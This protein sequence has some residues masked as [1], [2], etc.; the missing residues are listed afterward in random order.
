MPNQSSAK[1]EK[2]TP[3]YKIAMVSSEAVPYAKT[4]GLGDV[5][6]S[7]PKALELLG[8]EV[9]VFIPKYS[10]IDDELHKL[11]HIWSIGEIIIRVADH[12]YTVHLHEATL[13]GT[14]V[15]VYF[16]DC[17]HFFDRRWIYTNDPDECDRFILFN[18][19]V[20]EVIQRLKWSPDIIHCND[21]QTGL[22]PTYLDDH[23]H[24]DKMFENTAT[25]MTIH[26][27]GYPG[28]FHSDTIEKAHLNWN[29]FYPGGP[30][31]FF[32]SFSFLKTGIVYADVINTVSPTYAQEILTPEFGSGLEG[33]LL[34][35]QNDLYGILNGADYDIWNPEV[36]KYLSHNFSVKRMSNKLKIKKELM[37]KMRLPFDENRPLVGI[38]SR[39]VDQKGFDLVEHA[40]EEMLKLNIQFVVLGNGM[41]RYESMFQWAA[42]HHPDKVSAFIGYNNELSHLI[43]AGADMFL[44]PSRY[45]P[46]GLNQIYSLKYG[47]VPIVRRTG[48]LADTVFDWDEYEKVDSLKGNG[49]VFRNSNPAELYYAVRRAVSAFNDKKTWKQIM[50]NGMVLDYSW[51]QSAKQYID[52]YSTALKKHSA[53][54]AAV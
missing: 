43:E 16:I 46:C 32:D 10:M 7:L 26:N 36:D 29:K 13:P 23:F 14:S 34:A 51:T 33:L 2:N 53:K 12:P 17:A 21:W 15:K 38:I 41:E 52:L 28:K 5:I 11:Q 54:R 1:K 24:W 45:E 9:K 48:G 4:G 25:V 3:T 19:A 6:G 42:Y 40:F 20:L 44:M 35:R 22:I 27:I 30:Y 37:T 18:K 47:T 49:F 50:K 39:M 31:E 8:C